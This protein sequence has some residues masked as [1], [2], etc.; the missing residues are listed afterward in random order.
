M[1]LGI[2]FEGCACKGAFHVGAMQTLWRAGLR[3][4]RVAGSSSGAIIAA[5][6]ALGLGDDLE[7]LW[8]D[9]AGQRVFEPRR[10]LR[11]RWPFRMS[12]IVAGALAPIVGTRT[13]AELPVHLSVVITAYEGGRLVPRVLTPADGH[14]RL[15]DV[16]MASAFI[17]GVY[18]R[19]FRIDGRLA[20]DGGWV[21]RTPVAPILTGPDPRGIV[22]VTSPGE[23]SPARIASWTRR[24]EQE[25]RIL[26]PSR[27]LRIR[28]FDFDRV[29]TEEAIAEGRAAAERF[30]DRHADWLRAIP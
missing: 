2:A 6:V 13:L 21:T 28:A 29:V 8:L 17:P 3:P 9:L 23:A 5:A 11:G 16:L 15:L 14:L 19:P 18:H 25:L 4:A 24:P 20:L 26:Q 12:E 30:L 7:R 1:P 22:L 10:M 27:K